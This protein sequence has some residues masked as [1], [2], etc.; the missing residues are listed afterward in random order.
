MRRQALLLLLPLLGLAACG[1]DGKT[2]LFIY[3][4]LYPH[5]IERMEPAL[6][7][8]FPDVRFR[9]YQK[10]SEQVAVRLNAELAAGNT[11]C[12]LLVTSDP[13][14]YAQ[15]KDAGELLVHKTEATSSVPGALK[16]PDGAFCTVRI[17]V[18]VLAVRKD[19]ESGLW[20]ANFSD[21]TEPRLA[22]RVTMGDP[23]KSGTNFTTVAALESAHSW[24]FFVALRDR[25]ILAAGGNS[26][27]L[28]R[29]ET[30]ERAV[31]VILLENLL[32]RGAGE[33]SPVQVVFP[34][35]GAIPV[36]SPIAILKRTDQPEL[37]RRVFDFF[38]STRIQDAIVA[39]HMYSPLPDHP[40]P[41]G[42]PA[43]SALTL[44]PWT[45]AFLEQV[46]QDRDAIKT[47]WR[48]VM[49]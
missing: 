18:M 23:L 35:D 47:R 38:F 3:T 48:Q 24:D 6:H 49:R 42:A 14:Y 44:F 31:G 9:W 7:E 43:W 22:G 27:V 1:D 2:E 45:N 21:L 41:T 5:V 29:L 11:E 25:E 40:P 10:G 19:L 12:D 20:P 33:S 17:P 28:R 13:F 16:D 46:K 30:G 4:S 8:A 26:A 34:K 32:A 15:L 37:A 39:G 36:P